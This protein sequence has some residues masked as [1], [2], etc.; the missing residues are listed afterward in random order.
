MKKLLSTFSYSIG[1][2][3]IMGLT[4][5]FL[6]IFLMEHLIGNLLLLS[7][8]VAFNGYAEFMGS[9]PLI[10]ASEF[11]LFGGLIFHIVDGLMLKMQNAKARPVGYAVSSGSKNASWFSKNMAVT[12]TILLIF[13]ILHLISFFLKARFGVD[14]NFGV[15]PGKYNAGAWMTDTNMLQLPAGTSPEMC[16]ESI[17]LHPEATYSMWHKAAWLFSIPWYSILYIVSMVVVMMHLLHGFQSAFQ[18]LGLRH[19]KYTPIIKAIGY[20]YAVIVPAGF[21][22]IPIYFLINPIG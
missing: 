15:D 21:C 3:M 14:V 9:N 22:L 11:I 13:L 17:G 5:L 10:R 2:K 8:P 16:L 1:K 20:G 18:T 12:G 4:G 7:G 19:P 6:I